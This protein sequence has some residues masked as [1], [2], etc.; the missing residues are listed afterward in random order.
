MNIND[1]LP[2]VPIFCTL[3]PEE[4]TLLRHFIDKRVLKENEIVF[5]EGDPGDGVYIVAVGAVK[6]IKRIDDA[7]SKVLA[8]F[9]DGEFFGELALLD[10]QPRSAGAVAT[11][12]SV[13]LRITFENFR[14]LM[15]QAPFIALKIVSQVACHL[16]IR[17][18]ETN[19]KLSELE[20][21]RLL[22]G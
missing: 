15:N 7:S 4:L 12:S 9:T 17:L 22:R 18:R 10:G 1:L 5:Q 19:M 13:L 11:R 8:T 14:K 20:N 3:E 21:Y 16:S 2:N 6:A